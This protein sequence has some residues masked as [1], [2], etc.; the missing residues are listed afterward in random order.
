MHETSNDEAKRLAER[1]GVRLRHI[2]RE[3][4][5]SLDELA[6]KT[7]VSKLTLG[8]I[9]RG[10]ANPTL[11]MMWKITRGLS[12]PLTAL[13][14]MEE[15]VDISRSGEGFQLVGGDG[16]W[17]IEPMF[18]MSTYGTTELSRAFLE[19]HSQFTERHHAGSIEIATVMSGS[20]SIL[21]EGTEHVLKPF[22]SIR[23]H[24]D[25]E[26]TYLNSSDTPVV[27]HLM[28][29]YRNPD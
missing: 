3:H 4:N 1:V 23:F 12:V 2:R 16:N 15:Q 24:A 5:L 10:E 21:V 20:L 18:T 6:E 22:D 13:L 14:T 9:E 29:T 26:H 27:L 28:L 7:G 11:A 17:V 8:K 25:C 19:P